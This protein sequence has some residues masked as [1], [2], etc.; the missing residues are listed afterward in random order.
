MSYVDLPKTSFT[1]VPL[2][3]P[4]LVHKSLQTL[5]SNLKQ[6]TF[7]CNIKHSALKPLSTRKNPQI[8]P[9]ILK[10]S[11][12]TESKFG[13][14]DNQDIFNVHGAPL[15][16]SLCTGPRQPARAGAQFFQTIQWAR[17]P[18]HGRVQPITVT[19]T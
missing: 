7:P 6:P 13:S 19:L 5:N 8:Q 9:I 11:T 1:S 2:K 16:G 12:V 4:H 18:P 15:S 3:N 10:Q 17:S 14:Q